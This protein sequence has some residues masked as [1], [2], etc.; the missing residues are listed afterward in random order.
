MYARSQWTLLMHNI[1]RM[2]IFRVKFIVRPYRNASTK[3]TGIKKKFDTLLF[4]RPLPKVIHLRVII[5]SSFYAHFRLGKLTRKIC[6]NCTCIIGERYR[7]HTRWY[8]HPLHVFVS[9]QHID[10][11]PLI[12]KIYLKNFNLFM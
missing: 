9:R 4:A 5:Q 7:T 10:C 12:E 6:H 3:R 2:R 1:L 8:L 11:V